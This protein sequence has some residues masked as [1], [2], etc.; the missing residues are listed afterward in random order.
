MNDERFEKFE[1]LYAEPDE[2]PG[3]RGPG[4]TED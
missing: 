3:G 2:R 4:L 1:P